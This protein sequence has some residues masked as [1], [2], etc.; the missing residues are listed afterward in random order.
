VFTPGPPLGFRVFRDPLI[1]EE[2]EEEE[3][4]AN[5]YFFFLAS[6]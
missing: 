3:K 1:T 2:E 5:T 4:H 6:K